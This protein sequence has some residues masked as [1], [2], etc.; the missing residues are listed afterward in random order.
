M[1]CVYNMLYELSQTTCLLTPLLYEWGMRRQ[2][3]FK[4]RTASFFVAL[5]L[6]GIG[7]QHSRP[8]RIALFRALA[9]RGLIL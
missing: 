7:L 8:C 1:F 3:W 4:K 9:T 2:N 5:G 6:L